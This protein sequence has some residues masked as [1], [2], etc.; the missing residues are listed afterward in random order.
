MYTWVSISH[1][2]FD[3]LFNILFPYRCVHCLAYLEA[4][5]ALCGACEATIPLAEAVLRCGACDARLPEGKRVCHPSF[6]YSYAFA[7]RYES[8]I[9]RDLIWALK[10]DL[11]RSAG[12]SL[13]NLIAAHAEKIQT[14]TGSNQLVNPE[15]LDA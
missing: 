4:R 11:V 10:F 5:G 6:P 7:A 13:G 2:V 8:E 9:M 1:M 12:E 14:V 3:S 15:P